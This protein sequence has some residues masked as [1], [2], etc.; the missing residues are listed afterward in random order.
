MELQAQALGLPHYLWTVTQPHAASYETGLRWLRDEI[1]INKHTLVTDGPRFR[2]RLMIRS[3]S[4][5]V[6]DSLAYLEIDR[7]ELIAK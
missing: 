6:T 7:I 4:K 3:S 5:R 2:Q 1:G